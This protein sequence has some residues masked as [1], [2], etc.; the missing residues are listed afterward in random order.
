MDLRGAE[1]L[2]FA[3]VPFEQVAI[4]F[5]LSAEAGQFAGPGGAP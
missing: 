4:E 3:V 5:G 1:T 2:V